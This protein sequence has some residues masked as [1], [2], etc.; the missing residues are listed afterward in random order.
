MAASI[1]SEIQNDLAFHKN[2]DNLKNLLRVLKAKEERIKIGG[3]K[4]A[5]EKQYKRGSYP[6]ESALPN[7]S[8]RG[9]RS[10]R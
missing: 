5:I 10:L 9:V 4:E 3:G 7:S 1:G 6:L 8:I 2:E